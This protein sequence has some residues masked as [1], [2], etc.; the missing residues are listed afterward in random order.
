M[1]STSE[2]AEQWE[3]SKA[4]RRDLWWP[5]FC[6]WRRRQHI[7]IDALSGNTIGSG[8]SAVRIRRTEHEKITTELAQAVRDTVLQLNPSQRPDSIMLDDFLV[9]TQEG[10]YLL[11]DE[12]LLF[13][14]FLMRELWPY[15]F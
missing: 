9:V 1:G 15:S 13:C 11:L 12:E 6:K 5:L 2:A 8:A 10:D 14:E 7:V 4:T 3:R